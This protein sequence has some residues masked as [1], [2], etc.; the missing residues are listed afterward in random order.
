[1]PKKRTPQRKRSLKAQI[2]S[3]ANSYFKTIDK[4]ARDAR[5]NVVKPFC[6]LHNIE[7]ITGQQGY[8]LRTPFC[9]V[10]YDDAPHGNMKLGIES[11]AYPT[12]EQIAELRQLPQIMPQDLQDVLYA[13]LLD[14]SRL[15]DHMDDYTP[16]TF[17]R[18]QDMV[19]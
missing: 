7:F 4:L 5:E 12:D 17:Q 10:W 3:A 6:N 19:A 8:T 2:Q 18:K 14:G 13:E 16:S 1:M 11:V 9:H 15:G